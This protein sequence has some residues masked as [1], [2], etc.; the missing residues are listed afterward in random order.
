MKTEVSFDLKSCGDVQDAVEE[1]GKKINDTL[2]GL[3]GTCT[4]KVTVKFIPSSHQVTPR[5]SKK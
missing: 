3:S 5:E 1:V 2:A 4:L